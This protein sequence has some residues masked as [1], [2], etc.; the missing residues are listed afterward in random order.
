[1]SIRLPRISRA[2][3]S[4]GFTLIE[5]LVVILI[6][7]ILSAIA[8]PAFLNQRKSA[9]DASVQSDLTNAGKQV[10]TWI[11]KQGSTPAS[12]PNS[13]TINNASNSTL[14]DIKTSDG[15]LLYF[16][17]NSAEYCI[18]GINSGGST[19]NAPKPDGVADP[20]ATGVGF[21]Y[22]S[23]KGG[24]QE[25]QCEGIVAFSTN[26]LPPATFSFYTS[27]TYT[28]HVECDKLGL[29]ASNGVKVS[30]TAYGYNAN[31]RE[32][33]YQVFVSTNSVTDIPWNLSLN[34]DTAPYPYYAK[35]MIN[36]GTQITYT[37]DR[38][39]SAPEGRPAAYDE[40]KKGE[41]VKFV[42]KVGSSQSIPAP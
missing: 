13:A 32:Q 9:V 40:I 36:Y 4:E 8:I 17:G 16:Y 35:T 18:S 22:E 19:S 5:L 38:V 14:S 3:D 33:E 24:L 28:A 21:K 25:G 27:G 7:G 31:T 41:S 42:L 37:T 2:E 29:V 26:K 6:I 39:I 15:T 34:Y 11:T 12:F 20:N 23:S 1:M 30:C 10:E